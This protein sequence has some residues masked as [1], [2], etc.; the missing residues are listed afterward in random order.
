[1]A[2]YQRGAKGIYHMEFQFRGERVRQSTGLTSKRAAQEYEAELKHQLKER[3]KSQGGRP[4]MNLAEANARYLTTVIK[5]KGNDKKA[6]SR[7]VGYL[8]KF[9]TAFGG[10]TLLEDITSADI[11]DYQADRLDDVKPGSVRRELNALRA[12]LNMARKAGRLAA[13]PVFPHLAVDDK[14]VRW[15]TEDEQEALLA[16]SPPWLADLLTFYLHTGARKGEALGLRW[17]EVDFDSGPRG[18]VRLMRTKNRDPRAVPMTVPVRK[19]LERL[20]EKRPDGQPLVFLWP[21]RYDVDEDIKIGDLVPI[22]DFKKTFAEVLGRAGI[23]DFKLHDTRHTFASRL[24]MKGQPL[25]AVSKL[26][27]HKDIQMTMRYAHLAPSTFDDVIGALDGDEA[28]ID[29]ISARRSP[30][31][32]FRSFL[33]FG[34]LT[35]CLIARPNAATGRA[36]RSST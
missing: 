19:M 31:L 30:P 20:H 12:V 10:D 1:V 32:A 17:D 18:A 29:I 8:N 33:R 25:I 35:V 36:W 28:S 4:S 7:D 5:L 23:E 14:R 22:G 16:G 11:D 3:Y 26:L 34:T 13:V 21:S 15:L 2:V 27:G 24:V 9:E 6:N